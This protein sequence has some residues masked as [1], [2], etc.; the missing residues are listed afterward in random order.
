MAQVTRANFKTSKNTRFADNATRSI[1]EETSRDMYEDVADSTIFKSD[2]ISTNSD[3]SV[4]GT[5]L[6]DR[7]TIKALFDSNTA[8]YNTKVT[9]SSAEILA[10]NATPKVLVPAQGA[11]TIIDVISCEMFLDYNSVAYATNVNLFISYDAAGAQ[12]H[13]T[14]VSIGAGGFDYYVKFN[15]NAQN[16]FNTAVRVNTPIVAYV[17]I[18]N[19]TAGNSTIFMYL[20]YRVITL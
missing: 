16:A 10:L 13:T 4:D 19:P 2:D 14:S 15:L 17:D 3:F 8:I 7:A 12:L 5:K 11:G 20:T 1:T 18:G 6:T 9:I